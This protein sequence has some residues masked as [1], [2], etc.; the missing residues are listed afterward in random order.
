MKFSVL[1]PTRNGGPYLKDCIESILLD[2]PDD[3]E[4]II[5][6][7]ANIDETAEVISMHLKDPRVK[8]LRSDE[9]LSVTDNWNNTLKAAEGEYVLMMGDDDLLLPGYFDNMLDII[10]RFNHPD[11]I[12][13]NAFGY[14]A[15]G[16]I[17]NSGLSYYRKEIFKFDHQYFLERELS[18]DERRKVLLNMFKFKVGI[19]LNMQ[20]ILVR[21]NIFENIGGKFLP[22]FPDHYAL[23]AM[24]LKAKKWVFVPIKPVIIGMSPKSFGHFVYSNQQG[25]GLNY[26]GINPKFDG[27]LPGNELLNGMHV[28]LQMLKD[29]FPELDRISINRRQ[30]V[31]RQVYAWLLQLRL[32]SINFHQLISNVKLLG[33]KDWFGLMLSIFDSQS[34]IRLLK[35]GLIANRESAQVSEVIALP[36]I[37]TIREFASWL[38]NGDRD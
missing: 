26:L 13:Y 6:D 32:S 16:S 23:N 19:P 17:S 21:R 18:K 33:I 37:S 1:L 20:T 25:N 30:Y 14:I 12:L 24:L 10:N 15:P 38:S 35:M 34:W 4:L 27:R 31:R 36:N 29:N 28:W 22:P 7:N 9:I 11:C 5:S 8:V 3:S 2:L